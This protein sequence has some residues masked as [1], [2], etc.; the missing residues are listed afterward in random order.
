MCYLT[1][2]LDY[3]VLQQINNVETLLREKKII[4]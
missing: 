4:T 2:G 3:G 1:Y